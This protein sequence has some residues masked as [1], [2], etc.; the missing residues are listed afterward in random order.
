MIIIV[1]FVVFGFILIGKIASL[2]KNRDMKRKGGWCCRVRKLAEIQALDEQ[3]YFLMFV[4]LG[5]ITIGG[6]LALININKK[7]PNL[8]NWEVTERQYDSLYDYN[9]NNKRYIE[10]EEKIVGHLTGWKSYFLTLVPPGQRHETYLIDSETGLAVQD[11][12]NIGFLLQEP[13]HYP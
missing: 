5:F 10:V 9:N 11:P 6:V 3:T 7:L 8:I 1:I 12:T 4:V 13:W 2:L